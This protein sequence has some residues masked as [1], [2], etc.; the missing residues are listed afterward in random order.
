MTRRKAASAVTGF[1]VLLL[2]LTAC[3][4]PAFNADHYRQQALQSV[5][6]DESELQTTRVVLELAIANRV[7]AT[8][9]D[10]I[11]SE[12]ETAAGSVAASFRAVQPPVSTDGAQRRTM[13]FLS[14]VEDAISQARIVIRRDDA[15]G[16]R[17]ALARIQSLL[18]RSDAVR[19]PLR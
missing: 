19:E 10:E 2:S 4:S 8:T 7:L 11:V 3:V 6:A 16:M 14:E 5:T 15:Q 9:A 18:V 17:S 1:A 12:A 13:R